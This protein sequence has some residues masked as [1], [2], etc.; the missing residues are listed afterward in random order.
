MIHH[1]ICA[2]I[3]H[4]VRIEL[5]RYIPRALIQHNQ[6]GLIESPH[7]FAFEINK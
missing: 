6:A 2:E 3:C 7:N 4:I 1:I 5:Y